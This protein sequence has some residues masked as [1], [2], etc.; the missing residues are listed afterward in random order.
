MANI[1]EQDIRVR[2]ILMYPHLNERSRRLFAVNEVI[3]LG[4][5]GLAAVSRATGLA[6][7]TILRGLDDVDDDEVLD[8]NLIRR[9][10]GG[11]RAV[12][13]TNHEALEC[14][15]KLV[16]SSVLGDP[17]RALL[18]TSKSLD[19]L[20]VALEEA[21]HKVC[22][23]T[24]RK[25][26]TE[27]GYSRQPNRKSQEGKQHPDRDAQFEHINAVAIAFQ[28]GNSPVIS[29]DTKKKELIGNFKNAGTD[30]RPTGCP[31]EV[32]THD[33]IDAEKGKVVPYGIY[34]VGANQGWVS[35]GVDHD[36]S[37]FAVATISRWWGDVGKPRYPKARRILV[38]ADAGGSNG[39]RVR[40]W[41]LEL[42]RMADEFG[43]AITVCH[44]PP[45]TSKW[46]KIEHRLFCQITQNWR[47]TPLTSRAV[48]VDLIGNT[49]TKKGLTVKCVL[50]ERIYE[51]GMKV[52]DAQMESLNIK[53][54][55]FHPEWNYTIYPRKVEK[56]KQ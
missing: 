4:R 23:H 51:P 14:L 38:T 50:D 12:A 48:V 35:V 17:M 25:M 52:S 45:G 31:D 43:I 27:I 47:G 24:V 53:G 37:E 1:D 20:A 7:S 36:T 18:W 39:Y 29:V 8:P 5:G 44:F 49:R 22:T 54:S 33:F 30:Y 26:L 42:Q 41:K 16:E 15:R 56:S 40:L 10:G 34:D 46:N 13:K 9:P 6:R 32:L 28:E 55:Q 21:G 2:Y 19:K 3:A 11:R